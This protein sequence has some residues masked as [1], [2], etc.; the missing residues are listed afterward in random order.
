M[1]YT[2]PGNDDQNNAKVV[3]G[4]PK[5]LY[6]LPSDN[7]EMPGWDIGKTKMKPTGGSVAEYPG[8]RGMRIADRP[9]DSGQRFLMYNTLKSLDD[10][11]SIS[12]YIMLTCILRGEQAG[13]TQGKYCKAAKDTL[14]F[15]QKVA[16]TA[17][18]C[19]CEM[20]DTVSIGEGED[21]KQS[22]KDCAKCG[23]ASCKT[24]GMRKK[25]R[26]LKKRKYMKL[27]RKTRRNKK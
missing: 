27:N 10:P 5:N 9:R 23:T 26:T 17:N 8:S 11:N 22:K 4:E 14:E 19:L 12:K 16:S 25:R 13:S 3:A 18:S 20:R 6:T 7:K 1:R 15:A 2:I 21:P 24:G